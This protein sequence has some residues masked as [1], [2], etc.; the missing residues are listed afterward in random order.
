MIFNFRT[1]AGVIYDRLWTDMENEKVCRLNKK[2]KTM[3]DGME[4]KGTY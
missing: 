1:D 4:M 2:R 3:V